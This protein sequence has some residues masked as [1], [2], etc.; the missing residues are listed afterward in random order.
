MKLPLSGK[1][2]EGKF[3]EIDEED[4]AFLSRWAWRVDKYG[5]VVRG[6]RKGASRFRNIYLHM[7]IMGKREGLKMDHINRDP[8]DNRKSNLR[9]VTHAENIL[10]SSHATNN[11]GY[12]GVTWHAT[13][14]KWRARVYIRGKEHMLG[15][16]T[17]PKEAGEC[18]KRFKDNYFSGN[19][20]S[21][22]A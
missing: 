1:H 10:N 11:S 4:F 21:H 2:G 5:Y 7:A 6:F 8:L 12:P 22:G 13:V 17:C 14:H 16:F 9:F 18:V 19:T 15:W 20:F 3:A